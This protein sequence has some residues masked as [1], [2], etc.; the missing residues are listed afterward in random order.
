LLLG[1]PEAFPIVIL[2][3]TGFVQQVRVPHP[4]RN[5]QS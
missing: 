3:S 1:K 5:N 2:N 4:V